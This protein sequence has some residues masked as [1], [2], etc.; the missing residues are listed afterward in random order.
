MKWNTDSIDLKL[1][2]H[3][4]VLSFKFNKIWGKK[5]IHE[6]HLQVRNHV[7]YILNKILND[8]Y[9]WYKG[10]NFQIINRVVSPSAIKKV[11]LQ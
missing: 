10:D 2:L 1:V 11:A 7:L 3:L 9:T 6:N 4:Q 5:K 8:I